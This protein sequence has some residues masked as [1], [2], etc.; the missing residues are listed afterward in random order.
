MIVVQADKFFK[1]LKY[2]KELRDETQLVI[3]QDTIS[4]TTVDDANVI[5]FHGTIPCQS[6]NG[7]EYGFWVSLSRIY[8][9]ISRLK[10]EIVINRVP[11]ESITGEDH[12]ELVFWNDGLEI[13]IREI[14]PITPR[15]IPVIFYSIQMT[16]T[17][18]QLFDFCSVVEDLGGSKIRLLGDGRNNSLKLEYSEDLAGASQNITPHSF[19]YIPDFTTKSGKILTFEEI[20]ATL[21]SLNYLQIGLSAFSPSDIL[22]VWFAHDFPIRFGI[23]NDEF[24]FEFYLAPR[25]ET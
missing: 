1:L 11:V 2:A 24:T 25:I 7:E 3:K 6:N 10:G 21:Y 4:V 17:R 19:C 9:A 18:K 22:Q 23:W 12:Y 5:M 13:R 14:S 8:R 20:Q 16:V 15:S